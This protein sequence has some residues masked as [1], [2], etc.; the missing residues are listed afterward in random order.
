MKLE[1]FTAATSRQALA[2]AKLAFGDA[3]LILSNRPKDGGVEVIATSEPQLD[4]VHQIELAAQQPE[5][6]LA[7]DLLQQDLAQ[8]AMSTLSFQ[9]Y[10][11]ERVLRNQPKSS[12]I[13]VPKLTPVKPAQNLVSSDL[14]A[15][16]NWIEERFETFNWHGQLRHKPQLSHWML[17]LVRAGYTDSLARSV[18][19]S[20]PEQGSEEGLGN[21]VLQELQQQLKTATLQAAL[22]PGQYVLIGASGVGKTSV[23]LKIAQQT[24]QTE[25]ADSVGLIGLDT[26]KSG[27]NDFFRAQARGLGLPVHLAQDSAT[28]HDLLNLL[29]SKKQ[30]LIDLP[31]MGAQSQRTRDWLA[32]IDGSKIRR[33]LVLN[34]GA[35]GDT[36]DDMVCR[37]MCSPEQ[38]TVLTK[39]DE[40]A[41]LGPA[42][43]VCIRHQLLLFGLSQ[44]EQWRSPWETVNA[45]AL[46][47]QSLQAPERSDL[48][49]ASQDFRFFC[50]PTHH[51]SDFVT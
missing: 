17:K 49:P 28:L 11:R 38:L 47:Q 45:S 13:A 7:P 21:W 12:P 15:I 33:V 39:L 41:K 24:V 51:A 10:V 35:H 48:L 44:S 36:L 27:E 43:D 8:L 3:T 20:L 29:A 37:F 23:A 5:F 34:A 25:G 31:G 4:Q 46:L 16:K 6:G 19:E 30:V 32:S 1:K 9:D 42:L 2:K 18:L 40:A 22:G 14:Q 50:A 26:G